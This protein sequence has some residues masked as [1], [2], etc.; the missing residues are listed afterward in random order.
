MQQV[1]Q[2]DYRSCLAACV[3]SITELKQVPFLNIDGNWVKNYNK[4][5]GQYGYQLIIKH[6][7]P[8][9]KTPYIKST[10]FQNIYEDG[11]IQNFSHAVVASRLGILHDPGWYKVDFELNYSINK[12]KKIKEIILTGQVFYIE[13]N[14]I[15]P[16]K[17]YEN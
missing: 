13:V 11:E 8:K 6:E 1:Y 12:N 10:C 3:A 14:K 5:L 16:L 17:K 9:T 7:N 15:E 2:L 4:E